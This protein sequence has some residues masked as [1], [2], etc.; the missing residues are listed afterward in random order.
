[1]SE[2][3]TQ[4]ERIVMCETPTIP[5]SKKYRYPQLSTVKKRT[6]KES[7]P[8]LGLDAGIHKVKFFNEN[9][10]ALLTVKVWISP[11]GWAW[12]IINT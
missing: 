1:M 5:T 8:F 9:R 10:E 11:Y 6:G 4:L 7:V 2:L 3:L 12:K